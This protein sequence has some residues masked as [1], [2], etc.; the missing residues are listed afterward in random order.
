[1]NPVAFEVFGLEIRW[2][3]I[4]IGL[5]VILALGLAWY[6]CKKKNLSF[7]LVTDCFLWA[8]PFAIIGARLYY[9]IFEFDNYRDNLIDVFNIR[10]GG[11]AIHGGLIG[12]FLVVFI[13]A[14]VKKMNLIEYV[15]L[16]APSIILAQAIGRWGN[17]MNREAHGGP[18]SES[19]ISHFPGFIKEGMYIQGAYYHPTFLYESVWNLLV[20]GILLFILYKKKEKHNGIVICSYISLYSLGRFFVEGLRTDSLMFMG[21]RVAQLVSIIGIVAGIIGII[22]ISIKGKKIS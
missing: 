22:V 17:F 10:E 9:V 2:Y 7:D 21:L 13:F 19:F 8:F 12:A 16:A 15:D 4:L 5:G 20:C 11:L 6:N 1:M 18:V 3:G 14:K